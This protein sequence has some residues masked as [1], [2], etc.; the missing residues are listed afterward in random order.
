MTVPIPIPLISTSPPTLATVKQSTKPGNPG[1][2][3]QILK[4]TCESSQDVS[5]A[6]QPDKAVKDGPIPTNNQKEVKPVLNNEAN[7]VEETSKSMEDEN[8]CEIP[9]IAVCT[10]PVITQ[11]LAAQPVANSAMPVDVKLPEELSETQS[12]D[13]IGG[14]RSGMTEMAVVGESVQAINPVPNRKADVENDIPHSQ[15]NAVTTEKSNNPAEN[16]GTSFKLENQDAKQAAENSPVKQNGEIPSA[17]FDQSMDPSRQKNG[18]NENSPTSAV[19]RYVP[20]SAASE[21]DHNPIEVTTEGKTDQKEPITS[22][23]EGKDP[24]GTINQV[25]SQNTP[26]KTSKAVESADIKVEIEG[27]KIENE[28]TPGLKVRAQTSTE[29]EYVEK[30]P[31]TISPGVGHEPV[32]VNAPNEKITEPARLA[33]AQTTEILRQISRQISDRSHAGSQTIRIQLHPEEL[34]QIDLRITTSSQGTSISM[35][36]DQS[37]TGKLL[38]S[39]I[40][41]LKQTLVEAGVQMAD[42]HVGQQG[43]QHA[44]HEQ[45]LDQHPTRQH[46]Y[47]TGK[48]VQGS[49]EADPVIRK[50]QLTQID[51][52]I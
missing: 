1:E 33:E 31:P 40:S 48:P 47:Q 8:S 42:V 32:K 11:P 34:G 39:Q 16:L 49:D 45:H 5:D 21:A 35:V 6:V 26:E 46:S 15:P 14:K 38:E 51:Y 17:A 43:Q 3:E 44:F 30:P 18:S 37:S 7:V 27:K 24:K 52:R 23:E 29:T 28:S 22:S 50:S 2:F 12:P 10:Q 20:V 36:A 19:P 41:Q 25:E 4:K 9:E 13:Q